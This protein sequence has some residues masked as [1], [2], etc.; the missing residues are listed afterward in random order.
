MT[1]IFGA[2]LAAVTLGT[3]IK[4]KPRVHKYCYKTLAVAGA[5]S[6]I[7]MAIPVTGLLQWIGMGLLGVLLLCVFIAARDYRLEN[8]ARRHHMECVVL[9]NDMRWEGGHE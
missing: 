6:I 5:A 9:R 2:I 7:A 8:R 1:Q 4:Y 3:Y